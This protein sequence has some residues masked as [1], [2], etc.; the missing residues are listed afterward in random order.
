MPRLSGRSRG[1]SLR[2]GNRLWNDPLPDALTLLRDA[3]DTSANVV[4][5]V[6]AESGGPVKIGHTSWGARERRLAELQTGNPQRL[7]FRRIV[8][9][10]RWLERAL[11][12][13]YSDH[14]LEGEWFAL[15]DDLRPLAPEAFGV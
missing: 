5:I 13:Y 12:E 11:H 15:C 3:D 1:V 10:E 7:V 8:D 6:Q 14:R 2:E 9:G 4:Y